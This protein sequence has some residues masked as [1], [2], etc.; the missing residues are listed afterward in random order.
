MPKKI[1]AKTTKNVGNEIV[2][3]TDELSKKTKNVIHDVNY[4]L[5]FLFF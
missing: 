3:T 4:E 5:H 2:R 1:I